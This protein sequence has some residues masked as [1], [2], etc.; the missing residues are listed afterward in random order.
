MTNWQDVAN[1]EIERKLKYFHEQTAKTKEE[2]EFVISE[3]RKI[4]LSI[5][6]PKEKILYWS[7]RER[8]TNKNIYFK[9]ESKTFEPGDNYYPW[10]YEWIIKHPKGTGY[11]DFYAR[12]FLFEI[13]S[14]KTCVNV[15]AA[16]L[17]SEIREWLCS[18]L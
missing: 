7:Y 11:R 10:G 15:T 13:S 2:L 1:A 8:P 14:D 4:G 3:A 12:L 18:T 6:D 16:I 17:E 5:G 9:V